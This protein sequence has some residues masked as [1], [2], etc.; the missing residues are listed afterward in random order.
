M[1]NLAQAFSDLYGLQ[2]D[3]WE[4]HPEF[5]AF[6]PKQSLNPKITCTRD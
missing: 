5:I 4:C 3:S 2:Q 6:N 1:K